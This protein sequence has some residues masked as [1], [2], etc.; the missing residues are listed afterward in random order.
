MSNA[1]K[2]VKAN[3]E[4]RVAKAIELRSI[5]EAAAGRAYDTDETTKVTEL[6]SELEAID[7]LVDRP[8]LDRLGDPGLEVGLHGLECVGHSGGGP[9][10]PKGPPPEC[11]T[12]SR[13]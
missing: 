7:G 2:A 12:H 9:F 13:P 3:F 5:D 10:V 6:R 11:P 8:K 4:A 1:L